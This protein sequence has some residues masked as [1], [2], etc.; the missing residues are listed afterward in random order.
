[1][2]TSD[3]DV[4]GFP[5]SQYRFAP[6]ADLAPIFETMTGTDA[7]LIGKGKL[8]HPKIS[9]KHAFHSAVSKTISFKVRY[10]Y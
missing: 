5:A 1:M 2:L 3:V 6:S 10:Y 8:V 9:A 4:R 7:E